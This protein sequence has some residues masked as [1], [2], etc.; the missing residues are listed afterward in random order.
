MARP[1]RSGR[2]IRLKLTMRG[3]LVEQSNYLDIFYSS[4][5]IFTTYLPFVIL[6]LLI[7]SLQLFSHFCHLYVMWISANGYS[8]IF[9]LRRVGSDWLGSKIFALSVGPARG[10]STF[11]C[12][13]R[14]KFL[15][16]WQTLVGIRG[17]LWKACSLKLLEIAKD[18]RKTSSIK[19]WKL[20]SFSFISCFFFRSTASASYVEYSCTASAPTDW[21]LSMFSLHGARVQIF[22]LNKSRIQFCQIL[23]WGKQRKLIRKNS[24]LTDALLNNIKVL[25]SWQQNDYGSINNKDDFV[26]AQFK[27][28]LLDS[29]SFK[30]FA[31]HWN[32]VF[33][34][35]SNVYRVPTCHQVTVAC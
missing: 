21:E 28:A 22:E 4:G 8:K 24:I 33:F 23:S 27:T 13:V 9:G 14:S 6:R 11:I 29:E 2:V 15:T 7:F 17:I 25:D 1:C 16:R 26:K 31:W 30:I 5:A 32:G 10:R 12:R 35:L 20:C 3:W 19:I 34:V 18:G